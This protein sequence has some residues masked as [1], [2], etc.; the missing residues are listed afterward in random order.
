VLREQRAAAEARRAKLQERGAAVAL[1]A[2][3]S[4]A[5][6]NAGLRGTE[7]ALHSRCA[8]RRVAKAWGAWRGVAR[9]WQQSSGDGRLSLVEAVAQARHTQQLLRAS[10]RGWRAEAGE[11]A[12]ACAGCGKAL[13]RLRG[14][15][16]QRSAL[17]ALRAHARESQAHKR[18]LK[19]AADFYATGIVKRCVKVWARPVVRRA[20]FKRVCC[21]MMAAYFKSTAR[22]ALTAW[23]VAA[24]RCAATRAAAARFVHAHSGHRARGALAAWAAAACG[25]DEAGRAAAAMACVCQRRRARRCFVEWRAQAGAGAER[26]EAATRAW[27]EKLVA[28]WRSVGLERRGTEE[29]LRACLRQKRVAF[30]AF[31]M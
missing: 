9:L 10:L 26:W 4:K 1:R 25:G 23:A 17:G 6:A 31:K 3:R 12:G 7:R 20:A 11:A 14:R 19:F 5:G 30:R 8:Q 2:W 28:A 13:E 27:G 15:R 21:H 29:R 16:L 18:D 22:D 24:A